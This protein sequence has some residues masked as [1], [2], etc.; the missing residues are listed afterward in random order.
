MAKENFEVE[1]HPA[2]VC[3]PHFSSTTYL[4]YLYVSFSTHSHAA[5]LQA[6]LDQGLIRLSALFFKVGGGGG[7]RGGGGKGG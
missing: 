7:E 6:S 4:L 2:A 3:C 1:I 5:L